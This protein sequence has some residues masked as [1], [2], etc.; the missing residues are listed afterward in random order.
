MKCGMVHQ[1]GSFN[2]N[3]NMNCKVTL[4][5]GRAK[6]EAPKDKNYHLLLTSPAPVLQGHQL[7]QQKILR[8]TLT[9]QE[10]KGPTHHQR[11]SMT[12][13]SNNYYLTLQ[14]SCSPVLDV[15]PQLGGLTAC[16][17]TYRLS[18]RSEHWNQRIAWEINLI[19]LHACCF[20]L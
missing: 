6:H 20:L 2:P 18:P 5:P 9:G 11:W 8:P 1:K 12:E 3:V 19:C 10:I 14:S 4:S 16:L 15:I 7:S 13:V 17:V